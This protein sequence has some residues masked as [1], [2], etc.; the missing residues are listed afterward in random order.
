MLRRYPTLEQLK[1]GV[2][3]E[4]CAT[5]S[6]R[7][8]NFPGGCTA[9]PLPCEA[10]CPVFVHLPVLQA[11]VERLDPMVGHHERAVDSTIRQILDEED[12]KSGRVTI[13]KLARLRYHHRRLAQILGRLLNP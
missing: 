12:A 9:E 4:L 2:R 8:A 13:G 10:K 3:E 1:Q 11:V 5:C 6:F 7:A